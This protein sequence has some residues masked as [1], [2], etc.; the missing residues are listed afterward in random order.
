M[1]GPT[2]LRT[3]SG[4]AAGAA[5]S[6]ANRA[7]TGARGAARGE[8]ELGEGD[9][10]VGVLTADGF[11]PTELN[12]RFSAALDMQ[13][14]AA[15]VPAGLIHYAVVEGVNISWDPTWL[16]RHV[17]DRADDAR[18]ARC[19][20]VAAVAVG[21]R[22]IALRRAD[23]GWHETEV[24]A[25]DVTVQC[26]PSPVGTFVRIVPEMPTLVP[27]QSVAALTASVLTWADTRL[28]LGL[29]PTEPATDVRAILAL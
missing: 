11:R 8:R 20:I 29:G 13:G 28:G 22:T 16:E 21:E 4:T 2:P 7:R 5:P 17:V 3:I 12:P 19:H 25:A 6:E 14:A 18:Q 23:G 1:S 10:V 26:G 15:E 9:R 24:A 27:G